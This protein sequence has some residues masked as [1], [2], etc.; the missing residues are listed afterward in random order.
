GLVLFIAV[1]VLGP[2]W[3]W[4]IARRLN[5]T[6]R[7]AAGLAGK[8]ERLRVAADLHDIRGPHRQVIGPKSELAARLAGADAERATA[9]MEEVQ[10]LAVKALEDPR[11]VV[12]GYRNTSLDEEFANA[13]KV[14]AAAD[15]DAAMRLEPSAAAG[16]ERLPPNAR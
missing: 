7:L 10:R 13:T 15:I 5:E 9:E 11:A 14:L 1:M 6:Q 8:N 16:I 2:L 3:A 4:D 12:R